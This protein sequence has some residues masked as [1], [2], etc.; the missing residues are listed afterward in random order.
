MVMV[1]D[2]GFN[3]F[4]DS[5]DVHVAW[6]RVAPLKH[7]GIF[8]NTSYTD[9]ICAPSRRSFLSGRREDLMDGKEWSKDHEVS[10][11]EKMNA[12]GYMSYAL[13]KWHAG[14]ASWMSTPIGR[15]FHRYF[16]NLENIDKAGYRWPCTDFKQNNGWDMHYMESAPFEKSTS[17]QSAPLYRFADEAANDGCSQE[18]VAACAFKPDLL[19]SKAMG[20]LDDHKRL[21][22]DKPMFMYYAMIGVRGAGSMDESAPPAEYYVNCPESSF[23]N[24]QRRNFC[25]G[26]A[27][28]D[29]AI[30]NAVDKLQGWGDHFVMIILSDNGGSTWASYAGANNWPLRGN[31]NEIFEGGIRTKALLYGNHPELLASTL[32]GSTYSKGIMH[33]MDFHMMIAHLGGYSG[34]VNP[35]VGAQQHTQ[36]DEGQAGMWE[37]VV[38][39]LPSPRTKLTGHARFGSKYAIDY[40]LKVVWGLTTGASGGSGG[41]HVGHWWPVRSGDT[42]AYLD[43]QFNRILTDPNG[44]QH[45]SQ[46][47]PVL[48]DLSTDP[49]EMNGKVGDSRASAL[50]AMYA[51]YDTASSSPNHYVSPKSRNAQCKTTNTCASSDRM[52]ID[53]ARLAA[54]GKTAKIKAACPGS[55]LLPPFKTVAPYVCLGDVNWCLQG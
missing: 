49:Y 46:S 18:N 52:E 55:G 37:A 43:Q 2:M 15:G 9:V 19:N 31:K 11:A 54:A 38:N 3:D 4:I 13:G 7:G 16:G 34:P 50:Q 22:A 17:S 24:K 26:V 1:D 20:F 35:N 5:S 41:Q 8:I 53:E 23:T 44:V 40:P 48:F 10:I 39:N 32:K 28:V 27:Q 29:T 25:A 33:L 36:Q 6:Q 12:Q 42:Q 30:G 45:P 47:Q 21:H 14:Q 51:G